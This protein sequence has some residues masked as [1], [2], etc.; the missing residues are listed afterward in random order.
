L[1]KKKK[2]VGIKPYRTGYNVSKSGSIPL[3]ANL[4]FDPSGS[5]TLLY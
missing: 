5:F 1:D 3:S 2:E 4:G